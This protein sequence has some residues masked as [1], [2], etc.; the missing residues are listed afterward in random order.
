[1]AFSPIWGENWGNLV[2]F[3]EKL[4]YLYVLT[5]LIQV[6]FSFSFSKS[7]T[8]F[9]FPLNFSFSPLCT[10]NFFQY[11]ERRSRP[12]PSIFLSSFSFFSFF[13]LSTKY[14]SFFV[15]GQKQSTIQETNQVEVYFRHSCIEMV[16]PR[17]AHFYIQN[18]KHF[19]PCIHVPVTVKLRIKFA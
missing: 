14:N 6:A 7:V 16:E 2:G 5:P 19:E 9:F 12:I 1:M 17:M 4:N 3:D 8:I 10:I 11:Q 15:Q 13:F 18:I